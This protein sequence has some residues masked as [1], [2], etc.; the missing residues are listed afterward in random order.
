MHIIL[1]AWVCVCVCVCLVIH[2]YTTTLAT[3]QI[4]DGI[5]PRIS[6]IF[7]L[8]THHA[9]RRWPINMARA[10]AWFNF[11]Y[12]PCWYL[13]TAFLAWKASRVV[14]AAQGSVCFVEHHTECNK[15]SLHLLK[16]WQQ[17]C[18]RSHNQPPTHRPL[19]QNYSRN[20]YSFTLQFAEERSFYH[21]QAT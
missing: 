16:T 13:C 4:E 3:L 12:Q 5:V 7:L 19:W 8:W 20:H 15:V 14:H 10:T 18:G 9:A 21:D 6:V 11:H 1:C 2:T 17:I